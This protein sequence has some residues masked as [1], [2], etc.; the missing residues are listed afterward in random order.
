MSRGVRVAIAGTG[1]IGAVHARSARLAGASLVGVAASTPE[2]RPPRRGRARGRASV[3]QRRGARHG[4]RRR[5]RPHLHPEPSARA[6]DR[7]RAGRRQ[8]RDPGEA[9]RDGCAE[10]AGH[11]RRGDGG[12][13]DRRRPV[14]LPLLP[15]RARGAR[16]RAH[17]GDRPGPAHPRQLP[18]GLAAQAQRRQLARRGA[19]RRGLP[20]VRRHRLALV[21]PGRVHLRPPDH[22]PVRAHADRRPRARQD[23]TRTPP[24]SRSTAAAWPAPS[25]PRTPPSCSSRPT[26]ER[27]ARRSSARSPRVART[28]CGWRWTPREQ[29]LAFNQEEPESLWLGRREAVT[30]IKRDPEHLSA[31]A[32]R[33]AVRP[34]RP[35]AGLRRLLRRVRRRG[36]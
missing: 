17:G 26:T 7:G 27:S 31:A 14:R 6:A 18:P 24:S 11:H 34:A 25:A 13:Q 2:S 32:Q 5:R 8:A 29:A 30:L 3:R 16:A 36:L 20:R 21:R 1:F 35:P 22:A 33:Y 4:R 9:D 23:E 10:R 28:G 12:R 15:D 19:P